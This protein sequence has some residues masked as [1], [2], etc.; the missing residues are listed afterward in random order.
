MLANKFKQ[1][2]M[3]T[4]NNQTLYQVG[5]IKSFV[6]KSLK[7]ALAQDFKSDDEKIK[8]LLDTLYNVRDFILATTTENSVRMSLAQEFQRIEK[9]EI[10]GND[11]LQQ[12][13]SMQQK[14]DVSQGQDQ[15]HYEK[16]ENQEAN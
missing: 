7:D 1:T 8:Y 2:V 16:E 11:S 12:E 14:T 5:Q 4:L 9:E 10:L 13:E 15:G 6:D 3:P